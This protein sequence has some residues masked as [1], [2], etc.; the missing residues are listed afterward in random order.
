MGRGEVGGGFV[1]E[2]QEDDSKPAGLERACVKTG[3][4]GVQRKT[5]EGGYGRDD[6]V[7]DRG[8]GQL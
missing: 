6:A 2:I 7:H 3:Y 4:L 8:R 5:R 1:V